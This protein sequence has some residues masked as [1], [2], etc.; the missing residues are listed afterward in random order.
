MEHLQHLSVDIGPRVTGTEEEREAAEYIQ[1]EF[2][3]LGYNVSTQAF[4]IRG[5][6]KSQNVIAVKEPEDVENPEM[7]YV[8][9]PYDSFPGSPGANDNGSGTSTVLAM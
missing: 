1:N 7:I 5:G 9:A 6:E 3:S 8:T 4:D 2:A